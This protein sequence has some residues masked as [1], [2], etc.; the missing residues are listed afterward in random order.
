MSPTSDTYAS[1]R[2]VGVQV[3]LGYSLEPQAQDLAALCCRDSACERISI[4][5]PGG[6]VTISKFG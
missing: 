4:P 6:A 5:E 3:P 1:L 2:A